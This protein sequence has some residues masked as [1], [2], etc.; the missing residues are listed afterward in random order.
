M[1]GAG[2]SS[3]MGG[4]PVG[5]GLGGFGDQSRGFGT[6]QQQSAGTNF[7]PG[8]GP[9]GPQG[10]PTPGFAVPPGMTMQQTLEYF[11]QAMGV[12]AVNT[13]LSIQNLAS[14]M[15]N[16]SRSNQGF[17]S[18]KPKKGHNQGDGC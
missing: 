12:S 9:Q 16:H 11:I 13:N 8:V 1:G 7:G 15:A 17:R 18:L 4:F 5:G 3:G 10:M 14:S 6:G 2:N